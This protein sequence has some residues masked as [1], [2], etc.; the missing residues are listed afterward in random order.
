M[1]RVTRI[2]D[3]ENV[4]EVQKFETEEEATKMMNYWQNKGHHQCYYVSR[5]EQE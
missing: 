2:D 5:I 3:H 1:W 4:F